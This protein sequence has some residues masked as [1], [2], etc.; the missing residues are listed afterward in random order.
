MKDEH[1]V[2]NKP[3]NKRMSTRMIKLASSQ[4]MMEM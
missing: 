1:Y 4:K 2:K 3:T